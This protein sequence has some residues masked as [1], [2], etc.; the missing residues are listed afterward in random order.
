MPGREII[1]VGFSAGGVEALTRM[2]P[3][4]PSDFPAAIL[5]VQHFPG[6]SVSLLP[7]ILSRLGHLPA[8]HGVDG[9]RIRPGHIYVSCPERHLLVNGDRIRL[10]RGPKEK[11]HRPAIDPLFRTAA[12]SYGP[13]VVGV[14]LSGTLDDG[15][16]GLRVI[17]QCGGLAVVQQP[18]DAI[19]GDM[20]ANAMRLVSVD[21]VE[22]AATLGALLV[23]VVS[24][25]VVPER[26]VLLPVLIG[27]ADDPTD[28][29]VPERG[30][31][32]AILKPP[33]FGRPSG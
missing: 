30:Q 8:T 25:I 29:P 32:H 23:T 12:R 28:V 31:P 33:G 6:H 4:L 2:I 7:R 9:E 22:P 15:T 14:L 13:R 21:H 20:P 26:A 27:S 10:S 1:V 24:G 11:G 16:D 3:D 17:K 19:F 18:E 5:I